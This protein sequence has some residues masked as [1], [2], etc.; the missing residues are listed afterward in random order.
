MHK[1][2]KI[3]D[4]FQTRFWKYVDKN[5]P[6][7]N[8]QPLLGPCWLW[9]GFL[10]KHHRGHLRL[11]RAIEGQESSARASWI[12]HFGT[13]PDG[14][15]I[16]HHCD[17]GQCVRP[18]HLHVGNQKMNMEEKISRRRHHLQ[19]HG[20]LVSGDKNPNSR[21]TWEIVK[22]IRARSAK[23]ESGSDLAKLYAVT[24]EN[25]YRIVH[26]RAWKE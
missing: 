10:D 23:G 21:L 6:L 25:I 5:G 15:M 19:G 24:K 11:G 26:G 4:D 8:H 14:K 18:S 17:N 2:H 20:E 3:R 22:D 9:T 1:L 13:I 7:P 12:V 16:L